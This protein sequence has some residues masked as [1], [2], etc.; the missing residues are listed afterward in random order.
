MMSESFENTS[1]RKEALLHYIGDFNDTKIEAL[2]QVEGTEN[3]ADTL[4]ALTLLELNNQE[5]KS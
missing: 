5:L 4:A 1:P 2:K 3:Y